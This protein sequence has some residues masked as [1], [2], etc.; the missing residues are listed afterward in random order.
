MTFKVG[1]DIKKISKSGFVWIPRK[2]VHGFLIN[3]HV[4]QFLSALSPRALSKCLLKLVA[5][6]VLEQ[7][8]R[9]CRRGLIVN[10]LEPSLS[11]PRLANGFRNSTKGG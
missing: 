8:S 4:S 6:P 3:S 7:I 1:D 5:S 9:R 2:V 11:A 10:N